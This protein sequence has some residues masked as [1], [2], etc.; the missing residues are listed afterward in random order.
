[1]SKGI[2]WRW[3]SGNV[4]SFPKLWARL[5]DV[6]L[7]FNDVFVRRVD[8]GGL[9]GRGYIRC[10]RRGRTGLE[11]EFPCGWGPAAEVWTVGHGPLI[12]QWDFHAARGMPWADGWRETLIE[13]TSERLK[14]AK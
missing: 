3:A 5:K 2:T 9:F 12:G 7:E 10:R 13:M 8:L 14:I 6:P 1:M 11:I 4:G